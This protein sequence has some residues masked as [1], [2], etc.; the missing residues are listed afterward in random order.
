[1][2]GHRTDI[3][4]GFEREFQAAI[5]CERYGWTWEQFLEQPERFIR[6]IMERLVAEKNAS[7]EA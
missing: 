2:R 4:E 3:P 7:R 6:V 5:L 1:M